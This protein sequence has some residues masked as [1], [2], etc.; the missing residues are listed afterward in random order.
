[1]NNKAELESDRKVLSSNFPSV[2]SESNAR[3]ELAKKQARIARE[4][5]AGNPLFPLVKN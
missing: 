2:L 4:A 5:I 3:D 1:M